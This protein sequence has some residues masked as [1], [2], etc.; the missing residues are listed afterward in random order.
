MN[1]AFIHSGCV[2][3]ALLLRWLTPHQALLAAGAAGVFNLIFLPV[4]LPSIYRDGERN[5]TSGVFLYPVAVLLLVAMFPLPVAGACWAIMALGDGAAAL[6]GGG[7]IS[8]AAFLFAGFAGGAALWWWISFSKPP[9]SALLFATMLAFI[10]ESLQLPVGNNLIVALA[11]TVML[12][13]YAPA[14][15]L[16]P[17]GAAFSAVFAL[18]AFGLRLVTISGAIAGFVLATLL[19]TF[20]GWQA[21]AILLVFFVIGSGAT[22]FAYSKKQAM[23]LA[24]RR[25]GARVAEQAIANAGAAVLFA[26]LGQPVGVVASLAAAAADT[27]ATEIGPLLG[28]K[29][30][31]LATG[32]PTRAGVSGG[33][34]IAGTI[35]G[36]VA[37]A[38]VTAVAIG[39]GGLRGGEFRAVLIGAAS[40]SVIDSLLGGTLEKDGWLNNE[41]VNFIGT[42]AA[43]V[44]ALG[45]FR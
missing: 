1:R 36:I 21:G 24:E 11:P 30:Y 39:S 17:Y 23:G 28:G 14:I 12:G 31:L 7:W 6:A 3:F 16:S 10:L 15:S 18:A 38:A 20:G 4:L 26:F 29:V 43:G 32:R 41:G 40:G 2:V 8:R 33:V 5:V 25:K 19:Y 35:A 27:V 44:I 45:L 34:S 13:G 42:A 9:W 37:A 22:R